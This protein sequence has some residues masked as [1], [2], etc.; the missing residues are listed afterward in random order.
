MRLGRAFGLA[1]AV[2]QGIE[3]AGIEF[4]R[5]CGLAIGLLSRGAHSLLNGPR[6]GCQRP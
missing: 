5:F 3:N 4:G 2:V 6:G 1:D